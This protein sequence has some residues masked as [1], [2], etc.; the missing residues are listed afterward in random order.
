MKTRPIKQTVIFSTTPEK[1]YDMLLS[2]KAMSA[3]HHG[4]TTMNKRAN[5]KFTVF[6]GYCHGYNIELV[7]GRKIVQAWHFNEEGWPDDHFSICTF[8]LEPTAKGTKLTFIQEDVP[9]SAY[10]GLKQG[11]K[12]Y[13]W[14]PIQ[15][16]IG[17]SN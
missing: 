8:L 2:S 3:I 9:A 6:D 5:G 15:L 10:D 14:E 12:D 13:Y 11:W 17:I 1:L 7:P 4:K 16:A